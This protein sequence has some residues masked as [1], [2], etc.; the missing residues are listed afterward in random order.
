M[1]ES[2]PNGERQPRTGKSLK[3]QQRRQ[4]ILRIAMDTFAARGYNNASLQEIADRAGVT[5]AGVLHY[6]RS[7]AQL[8]T[9]VLDLRDATDIEQL[10]PDRPRGLA[11]LRHLVDTVRRN[12]EREG[13]VRLYAVLSAESVTEG[14]PAQDF[15]RDRYAGLRTMVSE[16]LAEAS[17]LGETRPGLDVEEAATAIVAV[18]DGLQIQWLLAPGSVDMA[19]STDRVI[20]ALLADLSDLPT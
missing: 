19:A 9:S 20:T 10:G 13:I 8:L 2:T 17:E 11:F 6:F 18:M 15:F 14:H 7:K 5:Q 4:E 12:T 1:S 3:A 16:A